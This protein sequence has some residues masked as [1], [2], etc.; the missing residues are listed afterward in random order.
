M[1]VF[2]MFKCMYDD[3]QLSS[4]LKVCPDKHIQCVELK[5]DDLYTEVLEMVAVS[6]DSACSGSNALRQKTCAR[7]S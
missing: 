2:V 3:C 6:F 5:S 1:Y 7:I 4:S